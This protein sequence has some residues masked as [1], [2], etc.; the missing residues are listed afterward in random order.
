MRDSS[1]PALGF[2][3][4][5]NGRRIAARRANVFSGRS[6]STETPMSI[7]AFVARSSRSMTSSLRLP[8]IERAARPITM[9]TARPPAAAISIVEFRPAMI[10]MSEL[11]L[12]H[13]AHPQK[14]QRPADDAVAEDV[15]ADV[16]VEQVHD[17][18]PVRDQQE[19]DAHEGQR[20]EDV[21]RH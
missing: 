17:V 16:V 10:S 21:A 15:R 20:A 12:H 9:T 4:R 7:P 13:L 14:P 6:R 11:Y 19:Q 5:A 2:T 18:R 8:K 1:S 3:S